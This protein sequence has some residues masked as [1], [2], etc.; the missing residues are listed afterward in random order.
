MLTDAVIT[1]SIQ[2]F[3]WYLRQRNQKQ[4]QYAE[5]KKDV[6]MY[7]WNIKCSVRNS[8]ATY[9][10]IQ[11][12]RWGLLSAL[13]NE[14]PK[15]VPSTTYLRCGVDSSLAACVCC[16]VCVTVSIRKS[17]CGLSSNWTKRN[18]YWAETAHNMDKIPCCRYL[19]ELCYVAK[20]IPKHIDN[21]DGM[22]LFGIFDTMHV[23]LCGNFGFNLISFSYHLFIRR[24]NLFQILNK[25]KIV[26]Y[27]RH[28]HGH[29]NNSGNFGEHKC[30]SRMMYFQVHFA[31]VCWVELLVLLLF[32]CIK[33]TSV[34]YQLIFST[35]NKFNWH[36]F[37]QLFWILYI[38]TKKIF[39]FLCT[40]IRR[41]STEKNS[42]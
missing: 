13:A 4:K 2:F 17:V 6:E 9:H 18:C 24:W 32:Y 7:R 29:Y 42:H 5:W 16:G 39:K 37:H 33:F 19:L 34:P 26:C 14:T 23:C 30:D 27:R 22:F 8:N 21:F 41:Y 10:E 35:N 36:T 3:A 25:N 31:H 12:V 1:T 28:H 15:F 11:P 40:F 38:L 20:A